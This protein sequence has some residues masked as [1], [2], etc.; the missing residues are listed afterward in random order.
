MSVPH[1][2]PGQVINLGDRI[3]GIETQNSRALVK[4]NDFEAILM[5]LSAGKTL[6]EHAVTGPLMLQCLRGEV[7]FNINGEARDLSPGDWVFLEA[8]T[9]HAVE[10][11]TD[12]SLLLTIVF[13]EGTHA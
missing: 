1:V 5:Q 8:G 11:K 12:C 2:S 7:R 10:A 4:T 13:S 6:P 3:D 9:S